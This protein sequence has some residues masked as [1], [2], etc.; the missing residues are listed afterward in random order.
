MVKQL[1]FVSEFQKFINATKSGKRTKL[2][3]A[4]IK[5]ATIENYRN[6]LK[7]LSAFEQ[8]TNKELTIAY[9]TGGNTQVLQHEKRYWAKFYREF[10]DFLYLQ[11][12]CHDNFCGHVFKI[13]KCFFRYLKQQRFIN[14]NSFYENFYVKREDIRV[15]SLLPGQLSFLILDKTFHEQLKPCLRKTK[16]MFVFGCATALRFSDLMNLR[17]RNLEKNQ[18]DYFLNYRSLKTSTPVQL[19]LPWFAV[20]IFNANAGRK[21]VNEKVFTAISLTNFNKHIKKIGELAGWKEPIGKYRTINSEAVEMK[22][23]NKICRFCDLMSSHVMRKTGITFLLMLGLPEY[24]VRKVSGHAAH[25][26][27]FFR[28]VNFAQSFINDELSIAH[29]KL[30]GLYHSGENKMDVVSQ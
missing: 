3:G 13:I 23:G 5:P 6:V 22:N 9:N 29:Q 28:Y 2:S 24:L 19:K 15:I 7:L 12:G 21:Y 14:L 1:L 30:L 25:S 27:S 17:V 8:Y 10:S 20:E 16:D 11:K 18:S 4:K 26:P